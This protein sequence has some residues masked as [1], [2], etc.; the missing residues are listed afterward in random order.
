MPKAPAAPP[1]AATGPKDKRRRSAAKAEPGVKTPWRDNLEAGVMAILLALFLK[2]FLVEAYKIPSGSM[3]PTLMGMP[4]P[5][6]IVV[7]RAGEEPLEVKDRILVD[8]FSYKL[9]D[10]KRWEVAVFRYPLKRTQNFVKRLVGLPG[11]RLRIEGGDL[12]TFDRESGQWSVE[13]RPPGVQAS[14]WRAVDMDDSDMPLWRQVSGDGWLIDGRDVTAT[15]DGAI[16]YGDG[17]S[18]VDRYYDGYPDAI[19]SKLPA[20]HPNKERLHPVGDLRLAGTVRATEGTESVTVVLSEGQRRYTFTLPGPAAAADQLASIEVDP[21][22][23]AA[24]VDQIGIAGPRLEAG[25]RLRFEVENLDDRLT[26]RLDGEVVASLDVL[27]VRDDQTSRVMLHARGTG[28][29]FG[30][31]R[32]FRDIY[33]FADH[34]REF[35]IPEGCYFAMGDNTLDSSD[36]REWMRAR[37]QARGGDDGETLVFEGN[38]REGENPSRPLRDPALGEVVRF[39]DE[40]GNNHLLQTKP[41]LQAELPDW[42][43]PVTNLGGER[44]PF[45]DRELIVG[46]ALAVFWPL[47]PHKG[48]YRLRWVR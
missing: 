34:Q 27:A 33:Y 40:W 38:Q 46:R 29:E 8:K 23:A 13:R 17:S 43:V 5:G 42:L 4:S 45:I 30:D 15:G 7:R 12:W 1:G 35:E 32:L 16:Q 2:A 18:I 36:S 24:S 28:A 10:P 25:R 22:T 48:I 14:Q 26:M 6:D 37:Y 3:Q 11:D 20:R 47:A 41:G 19:R 31:L 21:V 44:S 39:T 9:R